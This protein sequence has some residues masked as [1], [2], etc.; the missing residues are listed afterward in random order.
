MWTI[1]RSSRRLQQLNASQLGY[2]TRSNIT[3]TLLVQLNTCLDLV[4][5]KQN[6]GIGLVSVGVVVSEGFQR[7]DILSL[8]E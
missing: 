1:A 7:L 6:Q 8:V 5:L 2:I 4:I 3:L